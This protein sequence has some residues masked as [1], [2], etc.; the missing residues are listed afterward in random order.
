MSGQLELAVG[1]SRRQQIDRRQANLRSLL[2][3]LVMS[4]RRSQRRAVEYT[5]GY[6][7]YYGHNLL[8]AALLVM[9]LCIGDTYFTLVLISYGSTELNPVLAW[10]LNQHVLWF[11]G[12][13]YLITAVCVCVMVMHKR[14]RVFGMK[15]S[16]VLLGAIVC[17]GLLIYYQ[18]HM[19]L[20]VI[21]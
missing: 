12:V 11:Y 10:L 7:D 19:L 16:H 13:K 4:R 2:Y 3:A 9:L 14:F 17:Y 5:N 8:I 18:V 20:P 15:G 1:E 6:S 21:F